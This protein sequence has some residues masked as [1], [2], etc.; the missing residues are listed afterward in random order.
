MVR[1]AVWWMRGAG[2][3]AWMLDIDVCDTAV[4][5]IL[6]ECFVFRNVG[7]FG[8]DVPGVEEARKETKTAES[9]VDEGVDGAEA[10]LD[11]DCGE[12]SMWFEDMRVAGTHLEVVGR[13][14]R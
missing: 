12:V 11:P 3:A 10:G 14:R 5:W 4:F 9:E 2:L 8:D 1:L 13:G 6:F 7:V